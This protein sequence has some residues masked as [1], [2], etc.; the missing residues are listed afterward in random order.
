MRL[1]KLGLVAW[2]VVALVI[3]STSRTARA[4]VWYA[5]DPIEVAVPVAGVPAKKLVGSFGAPRSEGRRHK[6][7]D[8]MAPRGTPVVSATAGEVIRVG[9]NRLGG[10]VVWVAGEGMSLF[11]YAHL[12]RFRPGLAVGDS[13]R[14]GTVLGYVGTT[15][16]AARTPPHL[17][18]AVHPARRAFRAVDPVHLLKSRGHAIKRG[19]IVSPGE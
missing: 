9:Q 16:N 14:A 8:I 15:G 10:N 3:L 13:V 19:G 2:L 6:G 1:F 12:D 7:I 5:S 17:H 4:L 11:Y 18:F